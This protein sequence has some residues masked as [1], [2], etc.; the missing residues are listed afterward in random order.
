MALDTWFIYTTT[1]VDQIYIL[2]EREYAY[3]AFTTRPKKTLSDLE[4]AFAILSNN[5]SF[6]KI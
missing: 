1:T 6:L 4:V 2:D 3:F 5:F